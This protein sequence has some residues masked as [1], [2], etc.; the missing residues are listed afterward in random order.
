MYIR[1]SQGNIVEEIVPDYESVL[2]GVPIEARYSKDFVSQLLHLSDD[3][4]VKSHWIYNPET[5][6]FSEPPIIEPIPNSQLTATKEPDQKLPT[7][8][9]RI[10]ALEDVM[11]EM[12]GVI[13]NE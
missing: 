4:K 3:T 5:E 6:T 12:L 2:P 7:N 8:E 10:S 9:E 11:L 1:L 13:T